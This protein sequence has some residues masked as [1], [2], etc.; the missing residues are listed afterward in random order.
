MPLLEPGATAY[1]TFDDMRRDTE[2]QEGEH[3]LPEGYESDDGASAVT[4]VDS[5]QEGVRKIEAI[6]LTWT[7]RSL[8]IAYVSIFLMAFC[9][10]LEGQTIMSLSAYATSAFSKHSLISTVLVVQNVVNAVIKPPMAK[11]ADVFGRFE[12][13]C[14]SILIYVLGYIQMAASSNVQ[15]YASAQIFY[16]AGS[17]G[18]QILQQVFIADSSS[19][20]NRAL[21][22]LLPELPF[23]VTV[24]IGPTIADAILRHTSWRWGYG[25]WSI[26]LPASFLPLALSL[27]FNQRKARRLNLIKE[28]PHH[29]RGFLATVRRTWYDLDIGGLTLLSAAVTLILVPL[30]LAANSKN[31]WKSNSIVAM[32]GVG[33]ICLILLPFWE[34]SKKLAPKPLL[35]LHLLKQRTALAGCCLAFF[36]FMAFYFSV[37]PYL[38]SY[39]QVV[40]NYDVATAGRVTQTFAFTS[41]IAAFAVSILI[42][43]TRRYRIYVTIG[44]VIY[45]SGLLMM[46]LYRKEGSSPFQVL[47]TQ[48]I[49]GMGGGLLNVPVQLGVQASASHQE[50]AAATAMFLTSM[51][52]GGAVGA[53]ISGAVWT[54]NIPRKLLLYLPEEHKSEAQEIFGKLTKALSYEMGTPVR[55]AINRSYQETMNKLL[56]LALIA[57]VPLI[58]L[59]LLMSNYRLDKVSIATVIP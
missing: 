42:K 3:L 58:P 59:S 21:L 4:S 30:T 57:T 16:A 47:G 27:L 29:R 9:T 51:E 18:L 14:V 12:A 40:Q 19:L 55:A 32:I 36:Y 22:A 1:G 44:C 10:S 11:V 28:R 23:L 45:T 37:Q 35:S 53:A 31:G 52:M 41:T 38:Y 6:N 13:F 15:T 39:L 8:A 54:H 50:V 33:L 25:M 48:I 2:Q 7:T 26:I 24:W 56:V 20:L 5:V 34:T 49:V 43:Y 46:L 17:T